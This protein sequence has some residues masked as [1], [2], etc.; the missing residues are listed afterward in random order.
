MD[1]CEEQLERLRLTG[2]DPWHTEARLHVKFGLDCKPC[3]G[4]WE[5]LQ[6]RGDRS[7]LVRMMEDPAGLALLKDCTLHN[8]VGLEDVE[9]QWRHRF[10]FLK[11]NGMLFPPQDAY[12]CVC[13][14]FIDDVET[15]TWFDPC[16]HAAVFA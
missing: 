1:A 11:D 2:R 7:C 16:G 15:C 4:Y 14:E 12:C 10:E 6:L 8:N 9:S 13:L 5:I 3:D